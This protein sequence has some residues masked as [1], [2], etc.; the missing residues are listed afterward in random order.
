MSFPLWAP[1]D[2]FPDSFQWV[3]VLFDIMVP[4]FITTGL[5]SMFLD[6]Y[7]TYQYFKEHITNALVKPEY[8]TNL[9]PEKRSELRKILLEPQFL[10]EAENTDLL[11]IRNLVTAQYIRTI[12]GKVDI[13]NDFLHNLDDTVLKIAGSDCFIE[14][15]E[16]IIHFR[17]EVIGENTYIRKSISRKI[18]YVNITQKEIEIPA[19]RNRRFVAIPDELYFTIESNVNGK[20][21]A[22][23]VKFTPK[24]SDNSPYDT[25]I[26]SETTI[27]LPPNQATEYN[28]KTSSLLPLDDKDMNIRV[29][30]PCK[31]ITI[32]W[33][34]DG[35]IPKKLLCWA[36][37]PNALENAHP[38]K[39][40][41]GHLKLVVNGPIFPGEGIVLRHQDVV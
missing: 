40:T 20:T 26:S 35:S 18:K 5:V 37:C 29:G 15:F 7:S 32:D 17:E 3:A 1:W 14:N 28:E 36:F 41:T 34:Y 21:I 22:V 23:D 39:I 2:V 30:Y 33:I 38:E 19:L 6:S 25:I 12:H 10:Q 8:L 13:G 4:I 11:D 27:T 24:K 16:I 31:T 9:S